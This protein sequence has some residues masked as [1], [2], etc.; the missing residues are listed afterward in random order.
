MPSLQPESPS[1]IYTRRPRRPFH[2]SSRTCTLM[3]RQILFSC[4]CLA[5]FKGTL[6][7]MAYTKSFSRSPHLPIRTGFPSQP[8]VNPKNG[9]KS[10]MISDSCY[11]AVMANEERLNSAII[12]DR[13]FSYVG[14]SPYTASLCEPG[15]P[16]SFALLELFRLQDT[17]ALLPSPHQRQ[18]C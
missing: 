11:E 16:C 7:Q 10:P 13:D 8:T 14:L 18:G 9:K 12:Y 2:M 5:V 1:L 4:P 17:R 6:A 3:V 15:S